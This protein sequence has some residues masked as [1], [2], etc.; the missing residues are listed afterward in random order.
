[1]NLVDCIVGP[2]EV[3]IG[4]TYMWLEQNQLLLQRDAK[5]KTIKEVNILETK[6]N[7]STNQT[8]YYPIAAD[9]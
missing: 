2:P 1:M 4:G 5:Q 3:F 8:S 7:F 9:P 6:S